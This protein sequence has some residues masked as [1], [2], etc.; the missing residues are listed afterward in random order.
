MR[1][2]SQATHAQEAPLTAQWLGGWLAARKVV[3]R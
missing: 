3:L 1:E 2:A